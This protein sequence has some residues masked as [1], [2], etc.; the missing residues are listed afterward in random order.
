MPPREWKLRVEDI[1]RSIAA[2]QRYTAGMTLEEVVRDDMRI[3]AI[4][5]NFI[6]IG[7]AAGL[8]PPE[9]Q[10]GYPAVP[11]RQMRSLRNLAVHEY[12]RLS[13]P[14]LWSTIQEDLPPLVPL[15]REILEKEP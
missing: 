9:V 15:F 14:R 8:V 5:W 7:E 4:A 6:I 3:G 10:A 13:L 12:F 2:I 11:W 1:I